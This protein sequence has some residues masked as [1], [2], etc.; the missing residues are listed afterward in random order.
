MRKV[1]AVFSKTLTYL[2]LLIVAVF[3]VFPVIYILLGSF[4][5]NTEILVGGVDLLPKKWLFSNYE[6]AWTLARFGSLTMNSIF[7]L[8]VSSLVRLSPAL[9]LAMFLSGENTVCQ[10]YSYDGAVFFVYLHRFAVAVS[11]ASAGKGVPSE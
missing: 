11:A 3:A 5:S 9:R 1:T 6:Q 7:I 2:F 4:K 8:P 10:G